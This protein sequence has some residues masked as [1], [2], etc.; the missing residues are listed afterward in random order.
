MKKTFTASLTAAALL[1]AAHSL[2]GQ[3]AP[4]TPVSAKPDAH[5][6]IPLFD[7][8][9]LSGWTAPEPGQWTIKDG[10][11]TG[12]GPVSHL[13]SPNTYTN[14]EFKAEVRLNH[15]GNSGM[16]FRAALSKGWP[17]GYEAQVENTSPDPQRTGSLYSF[18]K[19]GEQLVQDDTWWT[20]HIVAISNHIIILVNGK[21]VTDVIEDKNTYTA[22][23]LALQQH[24]QGSVVE[25]RNL[26]VKPLPAD[27][28]EAWAKA[29]TDLPADVKPAK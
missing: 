9:T 17:K 19:I 6:W 3:P 18:H 23:Y 16:Y 13:Y 1:L 14:L 29:K 2:L 24:N 28:K 12:Q 10:V 15:S 5:G 22:G 26:Q 27:A 20:Q 8:K 7:G 4:G 11:L 21:V 25:Y